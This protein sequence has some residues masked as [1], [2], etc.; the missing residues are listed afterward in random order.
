MLRQSQILLKLRL[1]I[2]QTNFQYLIAVVAPYLFVLFYQMIFDSDQISSDYKLFMILPLLYSISL[3]QLII[4]VISEEKEKHNLKELKLS[5]VSGPAYLFS[6]LFFPVTLTLLGLVL[7]PF[8]LGADYSLAYF[9]VTILTGIILSLLYLIISLA[10]RS[11]NEAQAVAVLLILV[12]MAL[13][14]LAF[15]N[16]TVADVAHFSFLSLF[17]S[18][19]LE[20]FESIWQTSSFLISLAWLLAFLGISHFLYQRVVKA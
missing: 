6:S 15:I 13:P 18:Y 7:I 5:N 14:L 4:P 3:G 11:V 16:E 10:C 2:Y 12:I 19:F 17:I 20:D 9:V 1:K 8:F